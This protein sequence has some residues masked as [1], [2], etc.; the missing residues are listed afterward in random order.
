MLYFSLN[1]SNAKAFCAWLTQK[2]R[3]AELIG[4]NQAYRL[5]KDWEWSVAVGLDE[6]KEGSPEEKYRNGKE[7][8][9]PWN[10]GRGTWP[11]PRGAGNYGPYLH[12]PID[13]YPYTSPVGSFAVNAHGLYD[14]GGNVWQWCEDFYVL[15]G[16]SW[17]RELN[18]PRR[19]LLSSYR[20]S[21]S[22]MDRHVNFGFR[23][24][25]GESKIR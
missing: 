20:L 8:I 16:G 13:V 7:D 10:Q 25:L 19:C 12:L 6:P 9:Y 1:L 14:M 24:V 4:T 2:E 15:R 21:S 17:A 3:G 5:P 18:D 11:L 22:P 23:A